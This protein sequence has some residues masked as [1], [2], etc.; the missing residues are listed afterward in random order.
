MEKNN[1]F[2]LGQRI[3]QLRTSRKLSQEQLALRSNITPTYLGL[4]ERNLKNPTIKVVEQLCNTMNISLAEFFSDTQADNS[5]IDDYSF[6]IIAQINDCSE[7]EKKL[8]LQ[9]I[10]DILRFKNLP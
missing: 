6:Q 2:N 1:F 5:S 3:Q 9:L 4:I 7:E 10:K 8:I